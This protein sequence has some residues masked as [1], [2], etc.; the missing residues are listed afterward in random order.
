MIIGGRVGDEGRGEVE[1]LV[2]VVAGD[3]GEGVV[4]VAIAE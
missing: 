4:E 1:T 3:D 2:G